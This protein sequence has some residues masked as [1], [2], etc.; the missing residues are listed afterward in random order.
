M[1]KKSICNGGGWDSSSG[2]GG[3]IEIY[4]IHKLWYWQTDWQRSQ[5][6]TALENA[7]SKTITDQV[8]VTMPDAN[9]MVYHLPHVHLRLA[10]ITYVARIRVWIFHLI[11]RQIIQPFNRNTYTTNCH[12]KWFSIFRVHT[13]LWQTPILLH[14]NNVQFLFSHM[15]LPLN[16]FSL[17]CMLQAAS[18]C[19]ST[20]HTP[21]LYQNG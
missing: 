10:K 16:T 21:V 4:P 2:G 5:Y 12:K 14:K 7:T 11:L 19:L 3:F 1:L 17:Y 6:N 9:D 8:F 13:I 15:V 20:R 18:Q